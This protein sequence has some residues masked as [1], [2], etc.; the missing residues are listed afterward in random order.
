[1]PG[2]LPGRGGVLPAPEERHSQERRLPLREP[3]YRAGPA[4]A[5]DGR[6]GVALQ[7]GLVL[8][9]VENLV[10]AL[11]QAAVLVL[12][13]EVLVPLGD[14]KAGAILEKRGAHALEGAVLA[15][16]RGAVLQLGASP[17]VVLGEGAVLTLRDLEVLD[18]VAG[19]EIEFEPDTVLT[20]DEGVV[21][22]VLS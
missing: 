7:R 10:L 4:R 16:G 21:A 15:F 20:L 18:V 12:T 14:K 5:P 6:P 13:S 17:V 22:T 19:T 11:V 9:L 3:T 8:A 2:G 1:M